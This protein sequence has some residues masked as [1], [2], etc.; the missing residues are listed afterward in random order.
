[1]TGDAHAEL[2]EAAQRVAEAWRAVGAAVIVDR[3]RFLND[4]GTLPL[5]L[6]DLPEGDCTTMVLL[7]ARGLG[8]HV[9]AADTRDAALR[10]EGDASAVPGPPQTSRGAGND[11]ANP[12]IPSAAG[13]LSVE[14]CGEA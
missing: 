3:T 5:V 7:G 13:A 4:D 10:D 2:R 14:R 6:P 12:K 1:A 8:F 9:S 11:E